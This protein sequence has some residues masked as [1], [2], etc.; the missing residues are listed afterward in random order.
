MNFLGI[1]PNPT[2][3]TNA[4]QPSNIPTVQT[5]SGDS[6]QLKPQLSEDAFQKSTPEESAPELKQDEKTEVN[7]EETKA[8]AD[9]KEVPEEKSGEESEKETKA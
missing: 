2:T 6:P 8:E 4:V 3:Q 1:T 9:S 5:A 7:A